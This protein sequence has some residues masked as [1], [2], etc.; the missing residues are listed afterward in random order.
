MKRFIAMIFLL[1]SHSVCWSYE[2]ID[3]DL[4]TG[5]TL[6]ITQ[7][8]GEGETLL[9]W[10]PS[11]R[12]FGEGY[13]T[14]AMNLAVLDYD[15]WVANLHESY[16]VPT[17]KDSLNEFDIEDLIELID[18]AEQKGFKEVFFIS[19]GRG[20]L[21]SLKTAYEY[22]LLRK[23]SS[24]LKGLLFFSPHL[25]KGRTEMG[26]DAEYEKIASVS[27]LPVYLLQPQYSTKFAR[28]WEIAKQLEKG[29]SPVFIH[30]LRGAQGGFFMRPAQDLTNTDLS[31]RENLPQIFDNAVRLL[32]LSRTAALSDSVLSDRKSID[33]KN[34][35]SFKEPAL[36]AFK[37]DK[38]APALVLKNLQNET[39]NLKDYKDSVVL[40]NF[41][42][43]WCRPCVEEIP[44]LSRLVDR[45]KGKPFKVLAVNIGE[46]PDVIRNFVKSIPVNFEI[47]LDTDGMA[48]RNWK[49]Y[50]YPSN[51][52]VNQNGDIPYAY[53]GALEWDSK[54]IVDSIE[55]VF[56]EK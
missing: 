29:G 16:I 8:E 5:T 38:T 33:N 21:L 37:G 23:H 26:M 2:N 11:E 22:Q 51:Y 32:K 15:V 3:I 1:F 45:M 6:N 42:A 34:I 25:V 55:S 20:A 24:L 43:T 17:G 10:L 13:I 54:N 14:V 50:A 7:F 31:I 39:I 27:N 48:L 44:S 56:D 12:G 36:H 9:L 46:S 41:W 47:L 28:S 40:V 19:A 49:V 30:F 35:P 52:L 53:R 4:E 18:K